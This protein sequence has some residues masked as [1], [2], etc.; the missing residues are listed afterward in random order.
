MFCFSVMEIGR[1]NIGLI[2]KYFWQG[3][4]YSF[5]HFHGNI[6]GKNLFLGKKFYSCIM[7]RNWVKYFR[8]FV[9]IFFRWVVR[10]TIIVS[11]GTIWGKFFHQIF[12]LFHHL[13]TLSRKHPT[14]WNEILVGLS[15]LP[16]TRPYNQNGW[17]NH[18]L[19]KISWF[20]QLF[21]TLNKKV[22]AFY[23]Q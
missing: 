17:K 4:Q 18:F 1:K 7:F 3:F 19:R 20:F 10:N 2:R 9:G 14:F 12:L 15:K 6:L 22:S 5:L 11:I 13:W 21:R 23:K 16:F 8:S